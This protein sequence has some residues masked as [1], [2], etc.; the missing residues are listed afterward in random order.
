MPHSDEEQ[1]ERAMHTLGG[2]IAGC[3]AVLQSRPGW[4][5]AASATVASIAYL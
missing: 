2:A 4:R 1:H 5:S 3:F